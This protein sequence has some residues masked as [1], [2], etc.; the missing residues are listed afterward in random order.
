MTILQIE[1]LPQ[2]TLGSS[3][4]VIVLPGKAPPGRNKLAYIIS[5]LLTPERVVDGDLPGRVE[6]LQSQESGL[7]PGT[8]QGP[9]DVGS[10]LDPM[11]LNFFT[12][13]IYELS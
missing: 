8:E 10:H 5:K 13:V 1:N 4:L 11:L 2:I 12:A 9:A 6:P 7:L 3:P